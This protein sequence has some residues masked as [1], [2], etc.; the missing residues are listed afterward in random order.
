MFFLQE[1]RRADKEALSK[2]KQ[3]KGLSPRHRAILHLYITAMDLGVPSIE[4]L[5]YYYEHSISGGVEYWALKEEYLSLDYPRT[6]IIS[7]M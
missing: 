3:N 7:P 4:T 2:R 5:E 1:K 6:Y